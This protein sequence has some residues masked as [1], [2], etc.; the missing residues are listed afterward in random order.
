MGFGVLVVG[1]GVW[2]LSLGFAKLGIWFGVWVLGFGVRGVEFGR[3]VG[4]GNGV[5]GLGF[6]VQ[7]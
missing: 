6:Q 7:G 1:S 4:F 3:T 2:G 5:Q